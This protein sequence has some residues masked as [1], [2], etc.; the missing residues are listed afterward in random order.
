MNNN[1]IEIEINPNYIQFPILQN[2][3]EVYAMKYPRNVMLLSNS[4]YEDE[5]IHCIGYDNDNNNAQYKTI[6]CA[7][8]LGHT[9]PSNW[10][11]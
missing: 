2:G 3:E 10:D 4:F 6:R 9:S 8:N 7:L 11:I 1:F 5:T